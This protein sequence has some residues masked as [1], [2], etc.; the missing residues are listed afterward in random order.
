MQFLSLLYILATLIGAAVL[1]LLAW[2][3]LK[4]Y[5]IHRELQLLNQEAKVQTKLLASIANDNSIELRE[6]DE[7]ETNR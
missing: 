6:A 2:A 4:L 1:C 3:P 5:S 7:L